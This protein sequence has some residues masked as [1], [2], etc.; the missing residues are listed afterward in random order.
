[1]KITGCAVII[2]L[3]THIK[4]PVP[5]RK[6]VIIEYVFDSINCVLRTVGSY[7]GSCL[8]AQSIK[9]AIVYDGYTSVSAVIK[10]MGYVGST[11]NR[12]QNAVKEVHLCTTRYDYISDW[13][14]AAI[15]LQ[16]Y[17]NKYIVCFQ[18]GSL[19]FVK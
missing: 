15:S 12:S 19:C 17:F 7:V 5:D 11:A 3:C 2:I 16:S 14:A 1:M 8:I 6:I 9:C 10:G 13:T 18:D 4:Q